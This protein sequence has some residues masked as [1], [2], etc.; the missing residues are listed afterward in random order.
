[1]WQVGSKSQTPTPK[2][3]FRHF[4]GVPYN[5]DNDNCWFPFCENLLSAFLYFLPDNLKQR[6]TCLKIHWS[7][8]AIKMATQRETI[9]FYV[10]VGACLPFRAQT[11]IKI[12]FS[13]EML[14][15]HYRMDYIDIGTFSVKK[16]K[17]RR[18]SYINVCC[19]K[20]DLRC[21]LLGK[22]LDVLDICPESNGKPAA[23]SQV[24]NVWG[25]I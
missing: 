20:Q 16:L 4:S 24:L 7:D 10:G 13:L 23:S 19:F 1:M 8:F 22:W 3:E 14:V 5:F 21:Y 15:D 11:Q 9:I 6:H 18:D 17:D 2:P 25:V 12:S